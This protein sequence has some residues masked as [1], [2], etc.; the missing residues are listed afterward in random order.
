MNSRDIISHLAR[1]PFLCIFSM[2][3]P[4]REPATY[5]IRGRHANHYFS[6]PGAIS[7]DAL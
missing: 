6:H 7:R 3:H 1:E 5:C 2:T 4:G